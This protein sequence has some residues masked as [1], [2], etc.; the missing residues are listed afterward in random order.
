MFQG[1]LRALVEFCDDPLQRRRLQELCSKQGMEDYAEHIRGPSLCLYDV[2]M[3]FPSCS[4]PIEVV[5]GRFLMMWS[6]KEVSTYANKI[7]ILINI[8]LTFS[9]IGLLHAVMGQPSSIDKYI[10]ANYVRNV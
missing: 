6:F 8:V 5:L 2:L 9:P 4:P 1:F 10:T 3:A 7:V